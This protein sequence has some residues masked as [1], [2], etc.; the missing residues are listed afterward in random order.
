VTAYQQLQAE[1]RHA[2]RLKRPCAARGQPVTFKNGQPV[3]LPCGCK[4]NLNV[5]VFVCEHEKHKHRHP[6][7]TVTFCLDCEHY[8]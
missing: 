2:E 4:S 7:P 8:Q 6:L 1:R 5:V 3:R